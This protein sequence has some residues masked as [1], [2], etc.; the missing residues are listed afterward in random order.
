MHP[1]RIGSHRC[2]RLPIRAA[3]NSESTPPLVLCWNYARECTARRTKATRAKNGG[4]QEGTRIGPEPTPSFSWRSSAEAR[5]WKEL[6]SIS[7]G[8]ME[9]FMARRLCSVSSTPAPPHR[10]RWAKPFR[11]FAAI[12]SPAGVAPPAPLQAVEGICD[13]D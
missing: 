7:P 9:Q 10:V 13:N 1:P 5:Q 2:K 12:L 4:G 3:A 6:G 11:I 8:G